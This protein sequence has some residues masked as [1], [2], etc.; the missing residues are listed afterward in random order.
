MYI[1]GLLPEHRLVGDLVH[2]DA[3]PVV[4]LLPLLGLVGLLAEELLQIVA[5][6]DDL[7]G[8]QHR[9]RVLD[10]LEVT[11]HQVVVGFH[12]SNLDRSQHMTYVPRYVAH[13]H[14]LNKKKGAHTV[15]C[16]PFSSSAHEGDDESDHEHRTDAHDHHTDHLAHTYSYALYCTHGT[17]VVYIIMYINKKKGA[18]TIQCIHP[19]VLVHD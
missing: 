4:L 18:Y 14:V 19:S 16:T 5:V 2:V 17:L 12:R 9:H 11:L 3:E 1:S 7:L 8:A 10:G 6:H 13:T 15:I